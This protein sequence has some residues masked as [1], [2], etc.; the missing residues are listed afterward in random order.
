MP[1]I[2]CH[3]GGFKLEAEQKKKRLATSGSY[4][5]PVRSIPNQSLIELW[6]ETKHA[7]YFGHLE[8]CPKLEGD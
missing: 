7:T 1:N 6:G 2:F 3:S 8:G 4:P 5:S